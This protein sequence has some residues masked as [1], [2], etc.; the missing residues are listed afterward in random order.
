MQKEIERSRLS[1]D[2]PVDLHNKLNKQIGRWRVKGRLYEKITEDLV[3]IFA[4]KQQRKL[5]KDLI[6]Q[7]G[8]DLYQIKPEIASFGMKH[9]PVT[10]I[11]KEG[12]I[13]VK[14]KDK[15]LEYK[16]YSQVEYQG[17]VVDKR[18]IDAWVNKKPRRI[19]KYHPW[20]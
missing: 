20:K 10:V 13:E 11:N 16:K 5:S 6:F 9:A 8:G 12:N 19:N 15:T 18:A 17:K 3:E 7:Y 4:H 2:L 1:I 14:Y